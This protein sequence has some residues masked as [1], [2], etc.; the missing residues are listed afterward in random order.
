MKINRA[1]DYGIR[2]MM[3][4]AARPGTIV[5]R[6]EVAQK[7]AIPAEFLAKIAQLLAKAGFIEIRKG[8][9]GGYILAR[10]PSQITL[11]DLVETL[12]GEISLNLCVGRPE[13]CS[14]SP[15]CKVHLVWQAARKGLRDFLASIRLTDLIEK[16]ENSKKSKQEV[17]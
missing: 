16:S 7:M 1:T 10:D 15:T 17:G 9:A 14:F 5:P 4:L 2:L 8:R 6:A 3:Y 12:E 11:L 13:A